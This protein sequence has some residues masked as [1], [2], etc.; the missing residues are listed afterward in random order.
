MLY[1]VLRK[2][3]TGHSFGDVTDGSGMDIPALL[4]VNAIC[5]II[6]PPLHVLAGWARRAELLEPAGITTAMEFLDSDPD[7][8]RE[9]WGHSTLRAVN[10]ARA[11]IET[12]LDAKIAKRF[13]GR[14]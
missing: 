6:G 4:K 11:E 8:I 2:L 7:I 3:S 13:D 5:P 14:N 1:R 10:K 9:A 12:M